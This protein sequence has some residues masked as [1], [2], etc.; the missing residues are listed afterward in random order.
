[1]QDGWGTWGRRDS[2]CWGGLSSLFGS[3]RN[4]PGVPS[5]QRTC[6]LR[7]ADR[8]RLRDIVCE[9]ERADR[10]RGG[11]AGTKTQSLPEPKQFRKS[12]LG[13]GPRSPRGDPRGNCAV[14]TAPA[15]RPEQSCSRAAASRR[16]AS[17]RRSPTLGRRGPPPESPRAGRGGPR[18]R[19]G[20]PAA[21]P[22]GAPGGRA[23]SPPTPPLLVFIDPPSLLP[24]PP[25]PPTIRFIKSPFVSLEAGEREGGKGRRGRGAGAAASQRP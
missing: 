14:P 20:F 22:L 13:R 18:T 9:G 2:T 6:P 12:W 7:V 25:Q 15:P 8:G 5:L 11:R 23:A 1:M 16:A 4:P 19:G 21:R 24:P 3:R 17:Q 10:T